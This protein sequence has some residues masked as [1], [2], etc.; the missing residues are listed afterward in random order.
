MV[1][2]QTS[3]S[4]QFTPLSTGGAA[5]EEVALMEGSAPPEVDAG[6]SRA[7]VWMDGDLHAWGGPVL[8]WANWWNSK[9]MLFT[10]DD[11]IEVKDWERVNMGI[12]LVVRALNTVLESLCDVVDPIGQVRHVCASSLDFPFLCF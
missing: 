1:V 6:L 2:G 5:L 3:S 9:A 10:L 8:R 7:L 11:A 4:A 12:E